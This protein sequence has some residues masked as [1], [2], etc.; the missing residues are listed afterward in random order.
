MP[1]S[2]LKKPSNSAEQPPPTATRADRLRETALHHAN[3][4]QQRKDVEAQIL[5][6][7]EALLDLPSSQDADAPNSLQE[8]VALIKHSIRFFQPSDYDALIGERNIN[9]Q[10]GYVLCSQPNKEQGTN[11]KYRILHGAGKG[12]D[13]LKFVEKESLEKWCSNDCGKRALFIKAQL[14]EEPAWTRRPGISGELVLLD[15]NDI[16]QKTRCEESLVND[17]NDLD[18]SLGE[19]QMVKQ[20]TTLAIERGD[21]A[22]TYRS[23]GLIELKEKSISNTPRVPGDEQRP[24]FYD[25]IEG[26]QPRFGGYRTR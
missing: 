7:T 16:P 22:A 2:I 25:S 21:G 24:E 11:A 6:A 5:A 15:S 12:A 14:N 20:M 13:A 19:E 10:C 1:R 26:Y 17:I 8:D 4:I 9:R 23:L 3:L 18:S